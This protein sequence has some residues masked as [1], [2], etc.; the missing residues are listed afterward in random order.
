MTIPSGPT[1][2]LTTR[3]VAD[4]LRVKERKVYDLAAANEIPHRRVTGKLL[5]PKDELTAWIDGG[6]PSAMD[7]PPIIAGSHDPLLDWAAREAD[8]G[9]ATLFDG[10]AAGLEA[11]RSGASMLSGL[12]IP[13][14]D[15]W[16]IQAVTEAG[17]SDCVLIAMARRSQGLMMRPDLTGRVQGLSDL[18]G[19]RMILRQPGAGARSLFDRLTR[20]MDLGGID[21]APQP[22]RT[23]TDAAQDVAQG[24]ADISFGLEAAAHQ[25]GLAFLPLATEHFDLLIDRKAYFEPPVQALLAFLHSDACAQKAA[26]LKGYDLSPLGTVRWVSP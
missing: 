13:E 22:A 15:G 19:L 18:G 26:Q 2:F 7:R 10:S 1:A 16:N 3:E 12:H 14:A 21:I 5:F 6:A 9:L 23:E 20:G 17:L 8:A 4:L 11:F 24:Q 25:Y